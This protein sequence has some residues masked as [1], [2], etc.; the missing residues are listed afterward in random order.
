MLVGIF[1][2]DIIWTK[3]IGRYI[4]N[5]LANVHSLDYEI[6]SIN[7]EVELWRLIEKIDLLFLDVE[8]SACTSG[9]EIAETIQS[10]GFQC[11]ICFL[12]SH[13]EFA[14]QGYKFNAFRYIDKLNLVEVDEALE[15]YI[16][17]RRKRVYINCK[18]NE[19]LEY[20]INVENVMYIEKIDRKIMYHLLDGNIF[21]SDGIIKELASRF[22][23][24]GLIQVQRSYIVNMRYI[25][26]YDSRKVIIVDGTEITLG[27]DKTQ[28]FKRKFFEWRRNSV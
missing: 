1:D 17:N 27:R 24:I 20:R 18:S 8:L 11:K 28:D 12:T 4:N 22:K 25:K 3:R 21:L 19:G 16:S 5:Y 26:S 10:R 9:F 23:N 6:A 14:M 2:D 13:T 15:S 7:C